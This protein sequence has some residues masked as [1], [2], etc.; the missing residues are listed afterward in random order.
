MGSSSQWFCN[1]D[2]VINGSSIFVMVEFGVAFGSFVNP[3]DL[4]ITSWF[5]FSMAY[6]WFKSFFV[7][8]L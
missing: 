4:L 6:A 2:V 3:S 8:E 1:C 5:Q 7:G